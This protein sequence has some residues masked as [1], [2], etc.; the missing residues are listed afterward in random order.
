M[1]RFIILGVLGLV[2]TAQAQQQACLAET[3]P[4]SPR[5]SKLTAAPT[6]QQADQQIIRDDLDADGDPDVL[7]AWFHAKRVRWI[8]ENDDMKATDVR[9]DQSMDA[10]QIDRDGD[11]YY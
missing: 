3:D 4:A 2:T 8:D 11:G 1:N 7:E 5:K 10:M 9:G 6:T